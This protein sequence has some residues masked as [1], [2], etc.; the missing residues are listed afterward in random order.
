MI[1]IDLLK[2]LKKNSTLLMVHQ[3]NLGLQIS[4][5]LTANTYSPT[6]KNYWPPLF[7]YCVTYQL[8]LIE[9]E[10]RDYSANC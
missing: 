5:L 3:V 4:S 7:K 1:T 2:T 8:W 6:N 9:Q 10:F